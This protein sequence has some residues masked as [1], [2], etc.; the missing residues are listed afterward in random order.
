MRQ[1]RD[2]AVEFS[3]PEPGGGDTLVVVLHGVSG[4]GAGLALVR[5]VRATVPDADVVAP[6]LR[7]GL[8]SNGDPFRIAAR[9]DELIHDRFQRRAD[10]GAAYRR[11]ILVAH[12]AGAVLLRKAYLYGVG[13]TEDHP[14]FPDLSPRPRPWALAVERLVLLAP[15][16][17]GWALVPRPRY[18]TLPRWAAS[19][20]LYLLVRPLPFLSRFILA[21]Q[22][23]APFVANARLQWIRR[24]QGGIAT[25]D[26]R[27]PLADVV[28]LLGD[29]DDLISVEDHLDLVAERRAVFISVLFTNHANIVDLAD[30]RHGAHRRARLRDAIALP[31]DELGQRYRTYE[32]QAPVVASKRAAGPPQQRSLV[33]I[34]HGIRDYGHWRLDVQREIRARDP[35]AVVLTPS[36]GYLP[37]LLFLLRG[38]RLRRVKRFMD[39]YTEAIARHPER[40]VSFFGHSYGTY[41]LARALLDYRAMRCRNVVFAGSVVPQ[42][43]PWDRVIRQEQ[44][45]ERVR[46]DLAGADWVVAVFPRF[47]EH[48]RL[49]LALRNWQWADIGSGGFNGFRDDTGDDFQN[50]FF[51][52]GHSAALTAEGNAASIAQFIVDGSNAVPPGAL[53]S[54]QHRGFELASRFSIIAVPLLVYA[55]CV[56]YDLL[57]VLLFGVPEAATLAGTVGQILGLSGFGDFPLGYT[58]TFFAMLLLVLLCI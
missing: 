7:I 25:A 44:R 12:S 49:F 43:F 42:D 48:L 36:Y 15:V 32:A 40:E 26:G 46:N 22:R 28:I 20:A 33:F 35:H 53:T 52:G 47:F 16:T 31:I 51:K 21:L 4:A 50:A 29:T 24:A 39:W 18:M 54:R 38:V 23:G 8:W 1:I 9:L 3:P 56:V 10:G 6:R 17:R 37:M 34:L 13:S 57:G 27:R 30:A 41:I 58:L 5:E 55:V 19:L 14:D 45:V 11:V 2:S